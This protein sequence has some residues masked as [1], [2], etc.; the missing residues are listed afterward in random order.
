MRGSRKGIPIPRADVMW[1]QICLSSS[2]LDILAPATDSSGHRSHYE[3]GDG[4]QRGA[5]HDHDQAQ[6]GWGE[7]EGQCQPCRASRQMINDGTGQDIS[8]DRNTVALSEKAPFYLFAS[9]T[10]GETLARKCW[11]I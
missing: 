11:E 1:L 7:K 6:D 5:H 2:H 4:R 10:F 3:E 8:Q 9:P